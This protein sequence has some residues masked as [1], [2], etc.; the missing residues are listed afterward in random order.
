MS[1]WHHLTSYKKITAPLIQETDPQDFCCAIDE[2]GP[3]LCCWRLAF[4]VLG[5]VLRLLCDLAELGLMVAGLGMKQHGAPCRLEPHHFP[6]GPPAAWT[7]HKVPSAHGLPPAVI[8]H[9][10]LVRWC[11]P[12]RA[13]GRNLTAGLASSPSCT[14]SG[15]VCAAHANPGRLKPPTGWLLS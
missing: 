6:G 9:W 8:S 3:A 4:L 2:R 15:A 14:L 5:R 11:L 7:S 1:V 10:Q 13:T 12:W